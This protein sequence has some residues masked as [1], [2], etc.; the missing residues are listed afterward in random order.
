MVC[1]HEACESVKKIDSDESESESE[2]ESLLELELLFKLLSSRSTSEPLAIDPPKLEVIRTSDI[3]KIDEFADVKEDDEEDEDE[4]LD[5]KL[6][7]TSS[8]FLCS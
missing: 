7:M 3:D 1:F 6:S 8:M 5:T 4:E 2:S